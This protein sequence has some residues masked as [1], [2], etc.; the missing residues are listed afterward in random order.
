M[1]SAARRSAGDKK[2]K[3]RARARAN[4]TGNGLFNAK[5]FVERTMSPYLSFGHYEMRE[6]EGLFHVTPRLK[7]EPLEEWICRPFKVL[8]RVRSSTSENW[9]SLVEWD[10][11][12]RHPHRHTTPDAELHGDINALCATFAR[13]GLKITTAM[14]R[15]H[16]LSAYLNGARSRAPKKLLVPRTGWHEVGGRKTFVLPGIDDVIVENALNSPYS[17]AGTLDDWKQY[18]AGPCEGHHL[19]VLA[20]SMAFAAPLLDL[21]GE[22]GGG[23][24]IKGLSSIGKTTLVTAA[25]SVWGCGAERGGFL[26]TWRSTANGI[27]GVAA[28]FNDALLCLDEIGVAHPIEVGNIVYS[29][30][31][32]VGKQRARQDGS[33]KAVATWNVMILSSGEIGVSEKIREG[34]ARA[35]AGQEIRIID[36]AADAGH[37]FGVFDSA[38]PDGD[39]QKLANDIKAAA[40]TRYGTAGPAFVAAI[41][42]SGLDKMVERVRAF[43]GDFRRDVAGG[44]RTGQVLRVVDRLGL[45]AAAGEIAASLGIVGWQPGVAARAVREVFTSWNAD[46]G[47]NEPAEI[48]AAISQIAGLLELHGASRFDP[49]APGA[50]A[51]PVHN[52][53]GYVQGDGADRH[54]W[55][56]P[57]AWRNEFLKGYDAKTITKVLVERGL[58]L[59]DSEHRAVRPVKVSGIVMRVYVLPAVAWSTLGQ[60]QGSAGDANEV[61]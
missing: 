55:I 44:I 11:E 24:N 16:H 51:R 60:P 20:I 32:G 34:G 8:A 57:E 3:R 23:A 14:K 36:I 58:I 27:E 41:E 5:D 21:T 7:K 28:L 54:W 29:L 4:G 9:A 53:L 6:G 39:P 12:D 13:G 40:A 48:Q 38:G 19:A 47:G 15:K 22:G 43:Q 1:A 33:A 17:S 10:D 31:A 52:R 26:R 37:G 56:T 42:R 61:F 18:V 35:R 59:P 25:A 50:D 30:A 45:I 49:A 2:R 46:R